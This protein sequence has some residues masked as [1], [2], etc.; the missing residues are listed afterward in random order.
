[1]KEKTGAT[2]THF[3][4]LVIGTAWYLLSYPGMAT[5]RGGVPEPNFVDIAALCRYTI[6]YMTFVILLFGHALLWRCPS[7]QSPSEEKSEESGR[8]G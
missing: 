7:G 3:A 6:F 2:R 4:L 8:A 1:M 5:V